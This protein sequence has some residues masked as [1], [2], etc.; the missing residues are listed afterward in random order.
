MTE[1]KVSIDLEA[2]EAKGARGHALDFPTTAVSRATDATLGW[3]AAFVDWSWVLLIGLIVVNVTLRYVIGANFIAMEELQWH[4]YAIGFMLGLSYALTVD[5]HVRVDVLADTFRP[6]TRAWIEALG[7]TLFVLPLCGIILN[8]GWP[9]VLRSWTINEVSAAPGGLTNRW[10]IKAV[11]LVAF[12]LLLMATLSRLS[13]VVAALL[14]P[15][16]GR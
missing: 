7:L 11:I 9:F 12:G 15:S 14:S 4:L 13:R 8:Y 5:G 16:Y 10:A 1:F 2:V 6:R 3:I